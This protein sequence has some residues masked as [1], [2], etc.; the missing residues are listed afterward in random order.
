[1]ISDS[2]TALLRVRSDKIFTAESV[3]IFVSLSYHEQR[4]IMSDKER[5]L[6]YNRPARSLHFHV[7]EKVASVLQYR[8]SKCVQICLYI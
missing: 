8:K 2:L 3:S 4:K 6:L 5:K 1:M 7:V